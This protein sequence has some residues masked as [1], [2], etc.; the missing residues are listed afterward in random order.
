MIL[1]DFV[2][3]FHGFRASVSFMHQHSVNKMCLMHISSIS[4]EIEEEIML[5]QTMKEL[6]VIPNTKSVESSVEI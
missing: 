3:L 5:T 2:V 1:L 6:G 4:M